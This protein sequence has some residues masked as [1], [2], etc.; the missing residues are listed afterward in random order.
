MRNVQNSTLSL[1]FTIVMVMSH[2]VSVSQQT[3]SF[4]G[5]LSDSLN[6]PLSGAVLVAKGADF[7]DLKFVVS[8]DNGQFKLQLNSLKTYQVSIRL[9]GYKT[10]RDTIT[11]SK[12]LSRNYILS[13]STESLDSVLIKARSPIK[14]QGDTTTYR[15]EYFMTGEERRARDILEKIPGVE[16]DS[17][18]N[19]TVEGK[20]VTR[21][22]VD[23]K[24]F[25]TG[26]EKLGVNNIPSDVIDE[27]EI[28]QNY[29]PVPFMKQL[30]DSEE[31]ALNIKL[32]E[33]KQNFLFGD[34]GVGYGN[35]FYNY[36]ANLF[37]YSK[38]LG[39]NFIGGSSNDGNRI[40]SAQDYIDFEGGAAMLIDDSDS[41]YRT[42]NSELSRYLNRN[43]FYK[44]A[45]VVG[46][47]NGIS[48]FKPR[49][50]LSAYS[51]WLNDN[52]SFLTN[53][54]RRYPVSGLRENLDNQDNVNALLGL[55]KLKLQYRKKAE[56]YWDFEG[57]IKTSVSTNNSILNSKN[58][59]DD[60]DRLVSNNSDMDSYNVRFELEHNARINEKSYI[61]WNANIEFG[62][63]DNDQLFKFN[64]PVLESTITTQGQTDNLLFTQDVSNQKLTANSVFHF[65]HQSSSSW[66]WEPTVILN[67]EDHRNISSTG[68]I[69]D[70]SVNSFENFGFN[71]D[72]Q[73]HSLHYGVGSDMVY[74]NIKNS[75]RLGF[76]VNGLN[77]GSSNISRGEED[78]SVFRLLPHLDYKLELSRNRRFSISYKTNVLLPEIEMLSDRYLL[79]NYNSIIK[80]DAT[81]SDQYEHRGN[82][83]YAFGGRTKG[84]LF[85]SS[86]QYNHRDKAVSKI[87]NLDNI[88]QIISYLLLDR[89]NTSAGLTLNY[90]KIYT[91]WRWTIR[92]SYQ[93]S[94]SN[95][96][97]DGTFYNIK[98][99]GFNY[100]I[101][102]KSQFKDFVNFD[103]SFNQNFNSY[104]G[105][106]INRFLNSSFNLSLSYDYRQSWIFKFD[107]IQNYFKNLDAGDTRNFGLLNA[108]LKYQPEKSNWSFD[109]NAMNALDNNAQLYS[110]FSDVIVNQ[111]EIFI[112]PFRFVL[113]ST[114]TF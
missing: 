40:F 6:N 5:I 34:A 75:L 107:Y 77:Y 26:D 35:S 20:E 1:Y 17:R 110:S 15:V 25:F 50:T 104:D 19:V 60:N 47:L 23:G 51:V 8:K 33:N 55:T 52:T 102:A 108:N 87:R 89:A 96:V 88:D 74:K 59:L 21:L 98:S 105:F 44:N 76:T 41:Y 36:H 7:N 81:I 24:L 103:V 113:K 82:L 57:I 112:L 62:G 106:V 70:G 9:L 13:E 61:T 64:E 92:P 16:V 63:N 109:L 28:I 94:Q 48:D 99:S 53:S 14:I 29:N 91:K 18:G 85:Y 10:K 68:E 72:V 93:F 84:Y 65:Y 45:S 39:L 12:D 56:S 30:T 32:K 67:Y 111:T 69:V 42:L 11:L 27:I 71:N 3:F 100:N 79:N 22:M 31:I 78:R 73:Y 38:K 49:I 46:A 97:I 2:C 80:G 43:D 95:E 101:S 58:N 4:K 86:L 114:Y 90:T 66:H 37:Y 83:N 54:L